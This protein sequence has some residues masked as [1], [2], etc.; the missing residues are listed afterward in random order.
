MKNR[1]WYQSKWRLE[2][3]CKKTLKNNW[4]CRKWNP[5]W[6]PIRGHFLVIW[7][8]FT[9]PDSLG[10]PNGS[11]ASPKSPQGQSKPRFP[12]IFGWFWLF[13][14]DFLHHVGYFLSGLRVG[15]IGRQASTIM[16]SGVYYTNL[17]QINSREV[18]NLFLNEIITWMTK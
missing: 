7:L 18:L 14:V 5:K 16:R 1:S 10:S 6:E 15:G 9:V 12:S 17:E 2:K 11:Q 8:L 4:T 3:E 13:V